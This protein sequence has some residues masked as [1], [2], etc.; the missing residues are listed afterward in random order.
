MLFL[1]L[2]GRHSIAC[3]NKNVTLK[4][5][6][7]LIDAAPDS[8]RQIN[9]VGAMPLHYLCCNKMVDEMKS[10]ELLKLLLEKCPEAVRHVENFRLIRF[11]P[12]HYA[13]GSRRSPEFCRVLIEAY[14]G[15]ER[16]ANRFGALP[17]NNACS[18]GTLPQ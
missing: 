7:L 6:Q 8:V 14:P 13:S 4:I 11:L 16:I 12:I 5:I 18:N 2:G 9:N 3:R 17:F 15:S 10:I 1:K